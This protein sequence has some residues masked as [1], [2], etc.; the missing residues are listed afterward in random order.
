MTKLD[1]SYND[2]QT[3]PSCLLALPCIQ[4]LNLLSNQ[5]IEI[6]DIAKWS[7]SLAV[8]DLS[9]NQLTALPVGVIAAGISSLDLS[10]NKFRYVPECVCTFTTMNSLDI[11]W[12][13]NILALP[14]RMGLLKNLTRLNVTGLPNLHD[15]PE[16]IRGSCR[17]CIQ[18]L[19]H[20]LRGSKPF[21][22][23]KTVV[24]GCPEGG[25]TTLVRALRGKERSKSF[26]VEPL[27]EGLS[28][29]TWHYNLGFGKRPFTFTMWELGGAAKAIHVCFLSNNSLHLL[30]FNLLHGEGGL[31]ELKPW[32]DSIALHAPKSLVMIVGTH[33][34][35]IAAE[36]RQQLRS[37]H[38]RLA[39][40]RDD[41]PTLLIRDI[42]MVGLSENVTALKQA[43][44][45]YVS[46]YST[47]QGHT[48]VG[49]EVP[50]SYHIL[51]KQLQKL[52]EEHTVSNGSLV[53]H[54]RE[55]RS[56]IRQLSITDIPDN[57]ELAATSLFLTDVG[58]LLHY[59]DRSHDLHSLYF[60]NPGWL[61]A[62]MTRIVEGSESVA[63]C[64]GI[65]RSS[66]LPHLLIDTNFPWQYYE[67]FISLLARF[68]IALPLSNEYLLVPSVIPESRP[69]ID[70][71]SEING[72][73]E[74]P[75]CYCITF[76]STPTPPGFWGRLLSQVIH[77]LPCVYHALFSATC[78]TTGSTGVI[79][80]PDPS[81]GRSVTV[82]VSPTSLSGAVGGLVLSALTT[83]SGPTH[84]PSQFP[85]FPSPL[86]YPEGELADAS[87]VKLEY[88]QTGLFFSNPE[89][90]FCIEALTGSSFS[91]HCSREGILIT[92]SRNEKGMKIAGKLLDL[93]GCLVAEWYPSLQTRI[94]S[95]SLVE[96]RLPCYEC[97][98]MD[99]AYPCEF[100]SEQCVSVLLAN[101]T[102]IQCQYDKITPAKNHTTPLD[103]I[104]PHLLF[105]DADSELFL[106][107]DDIEFE[108]S[109]V[110][111]LGKGAFSRVYQGSYK[112]E[113]VAIKKYRAKDKEAVIEL[114]KE[115]RVLHKSHHPCIV[116]LVGG[117]V[118]PVVAL[119]M[120][121]A[122]MESLQKH[123]IAGRVTI[124]RI[125][126]YRIAAQVASA[127]SYL[128]SSGTILRNLRATN[129]LLWSLSPSC[130]CHCKLA[131]F[132]MATYLPPFG[133]K[134]VIGVPGFT[135]PEMLHVS[136]GKHL[137]SYTHKAD[138]FS[139]GMLLYQLIAG[140]QPYHDLKVVKIGAAV[141]AGVRPS[142]HDLP[143]EK[144]SFHYLTRLMRRCW[145]NTTSLRPEAEE[146]THQL[147]LAPMQLVK[148]VHTVRSI[149]SLRHTC[150]TTYTHFGPAGDPQTL[151]ELWVCSD[152]KEGAEFNVYS[153]ET[154]T[155]TNTN[156]IQENRVQCICL[157]GDHVWV[158]C[159]AGIEYGE[160]HIFN[161]S[162]AQI[163]LSIKLGEHSVVTSITCKEDAVYVGTVNGSCFL[164]SQH[165]EYIQANSKPAHEYQCPQTINGIAVA[166]GSVWTSHA[167]YISLLTPGDLKLVE[168]LQSS[169]DAPVGQLFLSTNE[170]TIWSAHQS[171]PVLSAWDVSQKV[172]RLEID[173]RTQ[174]SV[175]AR[176]PSHTAQDAVITAV[177]PAVDTVWVGMSSG[178]IL[179]FH[180]DKL[181]NWCRPYS[182]YVRFLACI[183]NTI[184]VQANQCMVVSGA[185]GFR[186]AHPLLG[187]LDQE[188]DEQTDSAGVLI[189]WQAYN[190]KTMRQI[191]TIE[192]H[193]PGLFR[194][195]RTLKE[196]IVAGS[197]ED[198]VRG[199]QTRMVDAR[200]QSSTEAEA[201]AAKHGTASDSENVELPQDKVKDP[202]VGDPGVI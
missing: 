123:L 26:S 17:E 140:R 150:V 78:H 167:H 66:D 75:Y 154:M 121:K 95:T 80:Q 53:L 107:C 54:V 73:G 124:H 192:D 110:H 30:V 175:I 129:V 117:C 37:L 50:E 96:L 115:A 67:Q 105:Q 5:L 47:K 92:S 133:A 186:S 63:K 143:L 182:E 69:D 131:D 187:N 166:Q 165:I 132:D 90:T 79:P 159:T 164:F 1:L 130:L 83:G 202:Y 183:P 2:L 179:M 22:G 23:M 201:M 86:P 162:T 120:E 184:S 177:A 163:V 160:I 169:S 59:D 99:Y 21:H 126:T 81:R 137:S 44:C 19:S 151:N 40:L 134:G 9:H 49:R 48:I 101:N 4:E 153:L 194:N 27:V 45:N 46:T 38:E 195:H 198:C 148:L 82:H 97:K 56:I 41:Y 197:F 62:V 65:L 170:D 93:T 156:F 68:E 7:P 32:L 173:T 171:G 111:V 103:T 51:Y 77:F 125:V 64:K 12:N 94:G 74:P 136:K 14:D 157:C 106:N 118:Y 200:S 25:K 146:M 139:F 108:L 18:Y 135:A 28:I 155:K 76:P 29:S 145:D 34:D 42:V 15:P 149:F 144:T 122:P 114:Q 174:L 113:P 142:L 39:Q 147:C 199:S 71:V 3:I 176:A 8:L 141:E 102:T 152:G 55:F 43:I 193:A 168:T 161:T 185:K 52:Q 190:A 128:H 178:H 85:N 35:R 181:L 98:K 61:Y 100:T 33:L 172:R 191:K 112:G 87:V 16:S 31:E 6:P 70:S 24:M 91:P 138:I 58:S 104:A 89:M 60:V 119:L 20:R 13:T 88:W 116:G 180:E 188:H 10:H 109:D 72:D 158:G 196:V 57:S 36:N 11:S 84:P 189:V 127:L